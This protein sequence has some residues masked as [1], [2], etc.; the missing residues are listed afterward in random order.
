MSITVYNRR[1]QA[2]LCVAPRAN[3]AAIH[4][5]SRLASPAPR[6]SR[7]SVGFI[8][9]LLSGPCET[10]AFHGWRCRREARH[11][12]GGGRAAPRGDRGGAGG[13]E[14]G[15]G[16]DSERVEAVDG[17][18]A[19]IGSRGENEVEAAPKGGRKVRQGP[20]RKGLPKPGRNHPGYSFPPPGT[21]GAYLPGMTLEDMELEVI[22]TVLSSVGSNR[23]AAAVIVGIGGADAPSQ[24]RE[25][26]A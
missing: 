20:K 5:S 14:E 10:C 15:N 24:G 13:G 8:H 16:G 18:D 21:V 3:S 6:R 25:V 12:W 23:R 22:R 9:G 17:A 26:H 4:L 19:E 1:L 11:E 7:C 2:S